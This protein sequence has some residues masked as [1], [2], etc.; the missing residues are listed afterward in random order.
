MIHTRR[1]VRNDT[2][3]YATNHGLDVNRPGKL[4]WHGTACTKPSAHGRHEQRNGNY[5]NR[6]FKD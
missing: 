6:A 1:C 4:R 5:R 2:P 3:A